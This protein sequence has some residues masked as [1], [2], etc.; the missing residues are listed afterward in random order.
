V[1]PATPL[2]AT[3]NVELQQACDVGSVPERDEIRRWVEAALYAVTKR[4]DDIRDCEIVVR[5]VGEEESRD[6]NS[7]YRNK[8]SATNVLAFPA[9][10]AGI[11]G[12]PPGPR[13]ALGDLAIC[14]PVVE[15]E[16][17]EQG[18]PVGSHWGHLLI[19]GTLHLLG[20]DHQTEAEAAEMERLE[21]QIMAARGFG[22]PYRCAGALPAQDTGCT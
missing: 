19:H 9:D 17:L 12:L 15:R 14:G 6:L 16:A 1:K 3:L 4:C 8:D 13:R 21:V 11:P 22:D 7:R 2:S 18:K 10:A 20:Y 5:V